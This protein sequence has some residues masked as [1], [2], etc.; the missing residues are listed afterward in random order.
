MSHD[1]SKVNSPLTIS[2]R[3]KSIGR[4]QRDCIFEWARLN[5][6][7]I[8][9]F[10]DQLAA[11]PKWQ[12]SFRG[13][14]NNLQLLYLRLFNEEAR[15]VE[16]ME[17]QLKY[18]VELLVAEER[19]CLEKH[20]KELAVRKSR[21]L[22][23]ESVTADS[24]FAERTQ[25]RS[26]LPSL[27][28]WPS[29]RKSNKKRPRVTSGDEPEPKRRCLTRSKVTGIF[30]SGATAALIKEWFPNQKE[31]VVSETALMPEDLL[32]VSLEEVIFTAEWI[33]AEIFA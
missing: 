28:K 14:Y 7:K 5:P 20:E 6:E 31:V 13:V 24:E 2:K 10:L 11:N 22:Y 25:C 9:S 21:V 29:R 4:P 15:T 30:T 8:S 3:C 33:P 17:L 26:K 27:Q 19:L 12:I 1:K 18:R 16:L 23:L 32:D